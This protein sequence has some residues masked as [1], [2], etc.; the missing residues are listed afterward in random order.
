MFASIYLEH[1]FP[2]SP[3]LSRP[4]VSFLNTQQCNLRS[5]RVWSVG[6][7]SNPG[8]DRVVLL[9][10]CTGG[11]SMSVFGTC[12]GGFVG[13]TRGRVPLSVFAGSVVE[14][15]SVAVL[16]DVITVL[17]EPHFSEASD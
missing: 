4:F 15:K 1:A 8:V 14:C 7:S 17:L 10:F 9:A 16:F 2:E 3:R 6:T 5:R 11:N 13:F 12:W